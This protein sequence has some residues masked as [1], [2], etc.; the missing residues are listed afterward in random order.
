MDET[1]IWGKNARS[2]VIDRRYRIDYF[3][4][5][6]LRSWS[7]SN[8]TDEREMATTTAPCGKRSCGFTR[9]PLMT[10]DGLAAE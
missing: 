1:G 9:C 4:A 7:N 5:R 8:V 10:A 3:R 2:A 6:T